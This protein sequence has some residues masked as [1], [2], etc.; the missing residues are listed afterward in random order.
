MLK[1]HSKLLPHAR[2]SIVSKGKFW[3]VSVG[4][5]GDGLLSCLRLFCFMQ[6]RRLVA[7]CSSRII[8]W[9]GLI[10]KIMNALL[11]LTLRF[12]SFEVEPISWKLVVVRRHHFHTHPSVRRTRPIPNYKIPKE[13]RNLSQIHYLEI[14]HWKYQCIILEK[15]Y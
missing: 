6:E 7:S 12:V 9:S 2:A 1:P 13:K 3:F 15:K 14:I 10:N 5:D 4:T 11:F 8:C